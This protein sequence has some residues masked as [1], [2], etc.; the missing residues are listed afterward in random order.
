MISVTFSLFL[1]PE[2]MR[3]DAPSYLDNL[4]LDPSF[5]ALQRPIFVAYTFRYFDTMFVSFT[6]IGDQIIPAIIGSRDVFCISRI[7]HG[8]HFI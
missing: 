6:V 1:S 4:N 8:C 7:H 3:E 2:D 5:V